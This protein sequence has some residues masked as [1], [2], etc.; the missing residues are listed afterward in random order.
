[1][2]GVIRRMEISPFAIA[3]FVPLILAAA[4]IANWPVPTTTV[5]ATSAV[6]GLIPAYCYLDGPAVFVKVQAGSIVVANTFRLYTVPR[7]SAT[8]VDVSEFGVRLRV[9]EA[10]SLRIR[11]FEPAL[12]RSTSRS[13]RSYRRRVVALESLM[14]RIP[15]HAS[16]ED[17]QQRWR[18]FNL[19]VASLAIAIGLSA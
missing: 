11:A 5:I 2:S 19:G 16:G 6:F 7:Y 9:D 12:V 4:F 1:M 13:I 18:G 10:R 8:S 17:F 14:T 15:A 3:G